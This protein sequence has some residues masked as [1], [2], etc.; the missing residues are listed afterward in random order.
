MPTTPIST[1]GSP[2]GW[3]TDV[4]SFLPE[5]VLPDLLVQQAPTIVA[6]ALQGDAP[7][8]RVPWVDDDDATFV[9]EGAE[10]PEADPVLAETVIRTGRVSQLVVLS[11]EQ[12]NQTQAAG[13]LA[14]SV[15]RA[16]TTAA[17]TSVISTAK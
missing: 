16:V 11:R 15:A 13:L 14:D 17:T 6:A 2:R 7:V 4:Q 1:T 5:D 8:A 10:I 3:S 9:P 12:Y